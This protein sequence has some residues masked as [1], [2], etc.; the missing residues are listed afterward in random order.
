MVS[1]GM[2]SVARLRA[3]RL[4]IFD[5]DETLRRTTVPGQPCPRASGEWEVLPGVRE[6]LGAIAWNTPGEPCFGLASNQDQVGS[7]FYTRERARALLRDLAVRSAGISPPEEALQ[8]CPHRLGVQ[9]D[10]RKPAPGMLRRIMHAY[11]IGP[12]ETLFVGDSPADRA[13][14]QAAGVDFLD[15]GALFGWN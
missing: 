8:L 5:A 11:G 2:S 1:G 15:A 12:R 6:L 10:C 3:Y 7:G 13:A 14:A 4:C 9:C